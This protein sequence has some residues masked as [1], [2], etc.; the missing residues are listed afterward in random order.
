MFRL[1]HELRNRI[2]RFAI[3]GQRSAGA[4]SLTDDGLRRREV[5]LISTR[6]GREGLQL[7]APLHYLRQALRPTADILDGSLSDILPA[8]PDVI[9]LDDVA[10]LTGTET[11]DLTEWVRA[12]GMLLRFAGPH[13]AASDLSRASEDPLMPVRLRTG[14]RTLGGAMSWG[15]PKKL[16]P[17]TAESPFFGLTIPDDVEVTA[18]VLAQ[19]DPTLASRVIAALADGTPLVTRKRM[20]QG[21]VVLFHV[22]ANAQWSTLPLSGLFVD[23]LERLAVSTRAEVPDAEALA[24]TSWMPEKLLNG[25]GDLARATSPEPVPGARLAQAVAGPDLPPGIYAGEDRKLAVNVLT[26]DAVLAPA[27]WPARVPV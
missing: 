9:V 2:S 27:L 5:A 8:N 14:G 17:F 13:L 23:M 1:P 12:G 16:R 3:A 4:V 15:S 26:P 7:L 11:R 24:G 25:F 20:G 21:Q 6:S 22:T 18:Q 10:K 19:P